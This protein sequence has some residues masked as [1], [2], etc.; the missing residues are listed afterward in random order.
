MRRLKTLFSPITTLIIVQVVWIGLVVLWI[1]WF[2][3]QHY[4]L[5]NLAEKYRPELVPEHMNWPVLAGGIVMLALVL[6]GLYVIFIYWRRQSRLY[7][8]Q[9]TFISQITH[10]LKSPLAS[11]QLHLETIR[12]RKPSPEKLD[13]FLDTMLA[14]TER[15]NNLISNFLM[16][17]K[18]EQRPRGIY[19]TSIDLSDFIQ[20]CVD[21]FR[22]NLQDD[23]GLTTEIEPGITAEIETDGMEMVLRN[24]LENAF[25]YSAA[26][27]EV[28]VTLKR[29]GRNCL[30]TV[31]DN[32]RGID[33]K[34]LKNIFRMFYRVRSSGETIKGTG[35]GLYIV[36]S[37]VRRHNGRVDVSSAGPGKGCT[38][39]I[40]LP[41]SNHN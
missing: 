13:R 17:A 2:M 9:K 19:F 30:L 40:T 38:F 25:L 11:I 6:V 31:R 14:D 16:A 20:G 24:L 39:T 37:V 26:S 23:T 7:A 18:L 34:E 10:E 29:S 1:L 36:K 35:L 8:E 4:E 12:L 15:L 5:R 3:G 28:R 22:K 41:L 33:K 21:N 32:G 27:P